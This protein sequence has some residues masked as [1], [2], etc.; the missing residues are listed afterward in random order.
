MSIL[1]NRENS[2]NKLNSI[3]SGTGSGVK[4]KPFRF[5]NKRGVKWT[6]Q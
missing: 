1:K 6:I 5:L 2:K 3:L 4:T